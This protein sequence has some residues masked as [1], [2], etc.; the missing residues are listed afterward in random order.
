MQ[1]KLF[2]V[3]FTDEPSDEQR[4]EKLYADSGLTGIMGD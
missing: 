3:F 4:V 2:T 1:C